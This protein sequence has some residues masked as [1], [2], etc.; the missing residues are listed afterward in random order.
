[1]RNALALVLLLLAAAPSG[2]AP[3]RVKELAAVEGVRENELFGYGLVVGLAGTG[4]TERVFF[5]SQSISSMLGRLGIRIDPREVRVRNVAAVMVTARLPPFA[6]PGGKIDVSVSSM[7]N[8]RSLA[9]GVLV[10]TPLMGS[11]GT[12]YALSQGPVQV[13][14]FDAAAA[15]S[16]VR[17]N[18]PT[19]GRVPNGATIEKTVQVDLDSGPLIFTLT[20]P[21]FTT[22]SRIAAAFNGALGAEVATALDPAA[23][24]VRVPDRGDRVGL[25]ARLEALEVD[26]DGRA[27]VVI[28]ERTGTVVAGANVR[29][30]PVA[31]AHGGL[32]ITVSETPLVSQPEAFSN[33]RTV[34]TRVAGVD[35]QEAGRGAVALPATSNVDDLVRALTSLGVPPRDLVSILQAIK[36]AGALD[37]DLEVL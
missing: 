35:A 5:T 18:H 32:R 21:D 25:I 17:K 10:V 9:G 15:G 2:A 1:M 33:G 6:R 20:N 8:A 3:V 26:A 16:S 14:G 30:R 11:D 28:S 24:E 19:S 27:K 22:A 4:D 36:A 29:I 34:R 23:V 12:V 7:G 37:A 31:V 13:G